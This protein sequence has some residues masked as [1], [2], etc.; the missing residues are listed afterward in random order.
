MN[1]YY[2]QQDYKDDSFAQGKIL[3]TEFLQ[4]LAVFKPASEAYSAA[5]HEINNRRQ[6]EQL[7][8]IEQHEGK[9]ADYYSLSI[10]LSSKKINQMLEP[11][12]FD[13][14]SAMKLVK[15][16]GEQI[17]QLKSKLAEAQNTNSVFVNAAEQYLLDAKNRVRRARDNTPLDEGDQMMMTSAPAMVDGSFAKMMTSYNSMV[18]WFNASNR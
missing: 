15:D 7:K 3:H 10:M 4:A 13:A 18:T 16:L 12:K 2:Q 1:K 9:S 6:E 8:K 14:D 11:E 5:I 17:E